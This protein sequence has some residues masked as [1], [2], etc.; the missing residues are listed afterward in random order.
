M[1]TPSGRDSFWFRRTKTGEYHPRMRLSTP[2]SPCRA[3]R[4]RS[5][6]GWLRAAVI[7]GG[8]LFLA[9]GT[10]PAGPAFAPYAGDEHSLHLWHLDE[11]RPP[12]RDSGT[13]PRELTGLLYGARAGAPSFVN[14]GTAI[15][16]NHGGKEVPKE[17]P[18]FGPILLAKPML[19]TNNQDQVDAPFPIMGEDGAFTIEALVKLDELPQD[20]STLAATIVSMDDEVAGQRVFLFRIE[21]PGFLSFVPLSGNSVRGGGL[22]TIPVT[23]PH[24]INTRDWFHVAVTYSGK[25]GVADN[26]KL[27]WTKIGVV[28]TV[29]HQ[30]GRGTLTANLNRELG[31]FAIGNTGRRNPEGSWEYFPGSI[32][33]VRISSVAREPDDFFFVSPAL[34]ERQ[35]LEAALKKQP[36]PADARMTVR[37]VLVDDVPTPM[38]AAP[39]PLELTPGQHRLDFDFGFVRGDGLDTFAV[40][41]LLEGLDDSWLPTA[42]GMTMIWEMLDGDDQVISRT[43]FTASGP[44]PG[45]GSDIAD[46]QMIRRMEPLFVPGKSAKIRVSL[47]SGTPDTTGSWVI[48]NLSLTRSNPPRVNLWQ[49]GS[50]Q[51][52]E[53][54]NQT[55]G[56][57]RGWVRRG[58]EQG[59]ARLVQLGEN[60]ALGLLDAEQD[61]F[62]I[63]TAT[64]DLAAP[65]ARD[66]ETFLVSW[67][68]A[69]NVIPG[70]SLRATY[71]SVPSGKYTFRA[72]AVA[73]D[74][75]L[76]STD[77]AFPIV[78][79]E[80]FWKS[81]LFV[82][83][84]VAAGIVLI[85]LALFAI[86]RRRSRERIA[87]IRLQNVL[88]QDRARIARDM[89]DDL[90]TRVSVL[91]LTAS[92]VRRA[93]DVDPGKAR[94]Q[95]IRMESAARDL[96]QAMEGLVWAVNPANDT[97]DHLA[98]HLSGMA[99]D[100]FRDAPVRLRLFIPADL[101]AIPLTSDFRH[102]FALAVKESLNNTLK[103][104]GPCEVSL[105]LLA[106][107]EM[108][109]VDVADTGVGFDPSL[110][111]EGNGLRNLASRFE[112]IG[113]SF[114]IE[115]SVGNGTRVCFRCRFRKTHPLVKP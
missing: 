90:G 65:P 12:F 32:D 29:A 47:S 114:S 80:P 91:N 21:K 22:A 85:G 27:Y 54:S 19:S 53:R 45:W 110:P 83:L 6:A 1:K 57:P 51:E 50:F 79:R 77:L 17:R 7:P 71:L 58:N 102:H 59:I 39:A 35:R 60:K 88:E 67:S 10:S 46:S 89:H 73:G 42:R 75:D 93:L 69:Y 63:W 94:Q 98:A 101:P 9:C 13:S 100:L 11:A 24:A 2:S 30:I 49:N 95:V 87:K 37:Q 115:S 72:I 106:E 104:A 33:E 68:E 111:R 82:P 97:L 109:R 44:S 76:P 74:L 25:E 70:S 26:L 41:C 38:P 16:F 14:F 4:H 34:K 61:H 66:G 92:F 103:Y 43:A 99:H 28:D 20:A 55:S 3:R 8:L 36:R 105:T 78:I 86:Y 40:K 107:E 112:E 52:G 113:G 84:V 56:V 62:A 96:V 81:A 23:G 5:L 31:D 48:D 108:L 18:I 64:C 15:S